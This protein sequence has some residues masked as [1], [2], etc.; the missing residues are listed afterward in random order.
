MKLLRQLYG[1]MNDQF[2]RLERICDELNQDHRAALRQ[3]SSSTEEPVAVSA[4]DH[5]QTTVIWCT[6]A[7]RML[8]HEMWR[9]SSML[10]KID[11]S[12]DPTDAAL[13]DFIVSHWSCCSQHGFVNK[14]LLDAGIAMVESTDGI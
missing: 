2:E 3:S 13:R 8:G 1:Q 12:S 7:T 14:Q 5:M 10:E 6:D 9:K 11:Y 4:P